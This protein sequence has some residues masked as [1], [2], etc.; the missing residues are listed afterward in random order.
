MRTL[1]DIN[2][3]AAPREMVVSR[4]TMQNLDYTL[5]VV[6]STCGAHILTFNTVREAAQ[7][8]TAT[9]QTGPE[10]VA[11]YAAADA[12]LKNGNRKS[13]PSPRGLTSVFSV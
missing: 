13:S 3:V 6:R 7:W 12:G 11:W 8:I 10:M 5:L 1:K 9:N 2:K 4:E